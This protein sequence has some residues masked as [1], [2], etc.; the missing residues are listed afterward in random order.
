MSFP[1]RTA[2]ILITTKDRAELFANALRSALDQDTPCEIV[3]VDDA[4]TD[5][6]SHVARQLCPQATL[7]RNESAVGI[8][9]AR[10]QGFQHATG[11]VVFTLDDDATF[12]SSAVVSSVMAEFHL[13]CIGAV[14][15]P[16]IDH[17]PDGSTHQ[18][19]PIE[20][21]AEDFLCVPIFSGGANAI[22]K[23]L[24]D[25][26]GGYSGSVRQGEERG[27]A[28]KMLDAGA[29]V[30]VASRHHIDHYPQPRVGDRSDILYWSARNN[31]QFGWSFVPVN[32]L[33]AYVGITALKQIKNGLHKR[34]LFQPLAAMCASAGD[35]VRM[36]K[37]R[38][39]VS[40]GAY[41]AFQELSRRKVLRFSQV[42]AVLQKHGKELASA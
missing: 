3:V 18:R 27:V 17:L 4:S 20:A 2:T 11:D 29:L 39:P 8:I 38:T 41:A 5:E 15:I 25:A 9:A 6:T 12:S 36:W 33:P 23:E 7:L 13:P 10:T 24:F 19:L 37:E 21:P 16:L 42:R 14:T 28:L 34:N 1:C 22:R 26:C 30:R 31:F 32:K 35:C 40:G